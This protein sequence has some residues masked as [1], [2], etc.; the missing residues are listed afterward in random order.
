[1][2]RFVV[3]FVCCLGCITV[4]AAEPRLSPMITRDVVSLVQWNGEEAWT[5]YQKTA[6]YQAFFESGLAPALLSQVQL[7]PCRQLFSAAGMVDEIP[8]EIDMEALFSVLKPAWTNVGILAL[9]GQARDKS[10]LPYIVLV[11]RG[12]AEGYPAIKTVIETFA[13]TLPDDTLK[14][15]EIAGRKVLISADGTQE[16]ACWADGTDLVVFF[17]FAVSDKHAQVEPLISAAAADQLD[18]QP[19]WREA[20]SEEPVPT[21]SFRLWVNLQ[22]VLALGRQATESS[23]EFELFEK[24]LSFTGVEQWQTFAFGSGCHGKHLIHQWSLRANSSPLQVIGWGEKT[25]SLDQLPPLPAD[26]SSFSLQVIDLK[27]GFQLLI[28]LQARLEADP[29]QL[30]NFFSQLGLS[31]VKVSIASPENQKELKEQIDIALSALEP[32]ICLYQDRKQQ[33]LPWG[34]PTVAV[35]VKDEARLLAQLKKLGWKRDDRW[36]CPMFYET[37]NPVV[38]QS[39]VK[40]SDDDDTDDAKSKKTEALTATLKPSLGTSTVAICDGW[41]VW[42]IQPQTVRTFIL[43]SQGMLPRWTIDKIPAETVAKLPAK[44]ARLCYD[45]PRAGIETLASLAPWVRDGLQSVMSFAGAAMEMEIIPAAARDADGPGAVAAD[46]NLP[47]ASPLDI[48]P[49]ELVTAPLF[50]NVSVTTVTG[51]VTRGRTYGSTFVQN[52]LMLAVVGYFGLTVFLNIL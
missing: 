6:S 24:A 28:E 20:W 19:E 39:S 35:K 17:G 34:I 36:G 29:E 8:E 2:S 52:P 43:R 11:I 45:D 10:T 49:V 27:K 21:D 13:K 4:A 40:T 22:Q 9:G 31:D 32:V 38:A 23:D 14:E 12:G 3:L 41:L 33:V 51:N 48:P 5:A 25:A 15:S 42:G 37:A 44:F 46:F 30:V 16:G 1:M 47:V 26:V 18:Q 7:Y 50:P